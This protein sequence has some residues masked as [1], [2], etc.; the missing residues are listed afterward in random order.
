M[1]L[2][3]HE[4]V[5]VALGSMFVAWGLP[6][7]AD[8]NK[9]PG[10]NEV[11]AAAAATIQQICGPINALPNKT[12]QQT[13]LGIECRKMVQTSNG[14]PGQSGPTTNSLGLNAE[15]LRFTMQGI[16]PDENGA[17]TQASTVT[18]APTPIAGRLLELRRV[19]RGLSVADSSIDVDGVRVATEK[20]LGANAR[21][22]GAAADGSS[23]WGGFLN[24]NYNTG[25]RSQTS[26]QFG[27]DFDSWGVTGGV[28]YRFN[29]DVVAGVAL[30]YDHNKA[31]YEFNLGDVK[32]DGVSLSLY[33]NWTNGPWYVDGH[34]SYSWIDYDTRRNIVVPTFTSVPG[35]N[36]SAT[37]STKGRQGTVSVGVGYDWKAQGMTVTPYGRLGYLHLDIDGF[38]ESENISSLGLDI[39]SQSMNSLQT[40]LGIRASGVI[41]TSYGVLGP[42]AGVEWNHEFQDNSRNITAAYTFD[43][44]RTFFVIPTDG[45]DRDFFTLSLGMSAQFARGM[46]GFVSVQSVQGLSHVTNTGV[47]LGLRAEF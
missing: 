15:Q 6:A 47:T 31:D 16:A 7:H 3:R 33:G 29:P 36:T 18:S 42:Y 21:G 27:F 39:N 23:P 32:G 30:T 20:V 13:Q 10:M 43:P 38:T 28:D 12:P 14:L 5:A 19:S 34:L 2:R 45:P 4:G 40:A 22:G 1:N 24:A 41:S 9:I 25:D 46:A 11:Q 44:F 35:I 37:G 8:L 17:L 26:R